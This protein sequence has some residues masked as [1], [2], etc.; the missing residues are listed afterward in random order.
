MLAALFCG[1]ASIIQ[2]LAGGYRWYVLFYNVDN[3]IP[4]AVYFI[5]AILLGI[6]RE[7][8]ISR[9]RK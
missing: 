7:K 3:W 9:G 8:M 5:A 2:S 6:Y 4:I 1:T